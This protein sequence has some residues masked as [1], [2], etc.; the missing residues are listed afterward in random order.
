[1]KT[2]CAPS[3]IERLNPLPIEGQAVQW[4]T[5]SPSSNT[6]AWDIWPALTSLRQKRANLQLA[7]LAQWPGLRIFETTASSHFISQLKVTSL[8]NATAEHIQQL[9]II[10]THWMLSL[11][12]KTSRCQRSLHFQ[13]EPYLIAAHQQLGFNVLANKDTLAVPLATFAA[14]IG[15]ISFP[16]SYFFCDSK[17]RHPR[18]SGYIWMQL[19][20]WASHIFCLLLPGAW[21]DAKWTRRSLS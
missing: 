16:I 13:T 20:I 9:F 14:S 19:S 17:W 4:S 11:F 7:K 12:S 18:Y 5:C 15:L 6:I 10:N 21:N 8:C 1:M 2:R 3:Q